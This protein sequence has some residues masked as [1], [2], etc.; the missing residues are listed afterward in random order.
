MIDAKQMKNAPDGTHTLAPPFEIVRAH[1]VPAIK[2]NPPV[3]PPFLGKLVVLEVVFGRRATGPVEREFIRPREN[4]SAVITDTK[5]NIAHQRNF[6]SFSIRFNLAPLLMGYP[7]HITAEI[8]AL[9]Y[10]CLSIFRQ[11]AHP[12]ARSFN[13]LILRRPSSPR[14]ALRILLHHH[15]TEFV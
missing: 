9:F 4:V 10:R 2:R 14:P 8:L 6:A 15:P 12:G 11:I 3:L 1:T 5:W 13:S 7:L